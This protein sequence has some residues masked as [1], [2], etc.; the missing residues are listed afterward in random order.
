[1]LEYKNASQSTFRMTQ[2]VKSLHLNTSIHCFERTHKTIIDAVGIARL[3]FVF[4]PNMMRIQV[5]SKYL[6]V[7]YLHVSY[8]IPGFVSRTQFTQFLN[9]TNVLTFLYNFIESHCLTFC[10]FIP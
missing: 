8:Q 3:E 4:R 5:K 7:V 6:F 9:C 1:M 2:F 10:K